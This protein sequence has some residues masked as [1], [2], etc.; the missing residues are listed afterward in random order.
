MLASVRWLVADGCAGIEL[1]AP[2]RAVPVPGGLLTPDLA[3]PDAGY[4]QSRL[5]SHSGHHTCRP[6]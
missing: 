2:L 1:A 4:L 6:R 3:Q 5:L